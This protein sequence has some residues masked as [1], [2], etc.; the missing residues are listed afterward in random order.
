MT[1][2]QLR[3]FIAV[4]ERQH[5]TEAAHA[6][7]LT[8][9]ATSAAIAALEERHDIRLF[10]R[11][12]RRIA[13]TEL[14]RAFLPEARAVLARAEEATALL[15]ASTGLLRG[16]LQLA[17]SQTA[18]NYWL[19]P[20]IYRFHQQYPGIELS[21][22][23]MNTRDACQA[24]TEGAADLG[25]IEDRIATP[26]LALH[27]ATRD[28]M[29]LVAA[30]GLPARETD[31]ATAPWVMRERGSGTRAILEQALSEAGIGPVTVAL[32]LPSNEAVRTVIEAGAG[33][34]ALSQLVVETSL[35]N[36]RL[37]A[38]PFALPAREFFAIH[39]MRRQIS[40]AADAFLRHALLPAPA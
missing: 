13:L 32:E 26:A 34:S 24:V 3:I 19:P 15:D 17:A 18:A 33:I 39:A 38:L 22:K 16:R 8:Q 29:V 40:R 31:P 14:G 12:G 10:D 23:I 1:L 37:V 20:L 9:S 30:P 2:E 5:M 7:N 27:A 28:Q 35:A 6:L 21:L 11:I 25:F 4:A 36:G